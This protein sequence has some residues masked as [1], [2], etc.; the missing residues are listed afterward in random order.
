M[1]NRYDSTSTSVFEFIYWVSLT[2]T[3]NMKWE[4]EVIQNILMIKCDIKEL[5][6][7]KVL[8]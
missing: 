2:D 3:D 5:I 1:S 6:E 7:S 4:I 8:V